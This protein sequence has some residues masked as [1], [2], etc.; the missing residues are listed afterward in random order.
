[1]ANDHRKESW[2][3]NNHP[4]FK[5]IRIKEHEAK[6]VGKLYNTII[7]LLDIT[8]P[9][10]ELDNIIINFIDRNIA[11]DFI[12]AYHYIGKPRPGGLAIG[13]YIN[14]KLI[15][16]ILFQRPIRQQ[17]ASC[18][19]SSW[20]HTY[21]ISRLVVAPGYNKKN[22]ISYILSRAIKMLPKETKL[23]IAFADSTYGHN[24]TCYKATNFILERIVDP[25]YHYEN[26]GIMMHKK[27][28]W[29]HAKKMGKNEHD[30]AIE[31]GYIK[32][33]DAEKYKYVYKIN[34]YSKNK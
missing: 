26:D 34:Q 19:G 31:K 12:N 30:Y 24:G 20:D 33:L 27:T 1:M 15:A 23:I 13:G 25:D 14:A 9:E 3:Q 32:V 10:F 21:E 7:N 4:E 6:C 28:L 8:L 16:V 2:I 5:L 11:I 29:D 18:S 22:L 17:S